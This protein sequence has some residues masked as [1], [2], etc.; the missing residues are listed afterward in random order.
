MLGCIAICLLDSKDN[1]EVFKSNEG[2]E[3]VLFLMRTNSYLRRDAL[4]VL[5][6]AMT[7]CDCS[8]AVYLITVAKCLPII[9]GLL[10]KGPDVKSKKGEVFLAPRT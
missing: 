8:H 4:R 6:F 5:S 3:T 2:Y 10:M 9:F 1:C 7:Q